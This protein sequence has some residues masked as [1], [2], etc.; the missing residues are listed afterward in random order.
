MK[1][2][3]LPPGL[4]LVLVLLVACTALRREP[5]MAAFYQACIDAT[6]DAVVLNVAAHPDDEAARTLTYLRRKHGIRTYT[7]Y[8][9]C[10]GG[11]QNAIGPEIGEDLARIRTRETLAAARFTGARVRWMGF[12]DFG[13]SKTAEE[14]FKAWGKRKYLDTL[15]RFLDQIDPDVVFTNHGP[16]RGHGHH[17]ATAIAAR[18]VVAKHPGLLLFERMPGDMWFE[19]PDVPSGPARPDVVFPVTEVDPSTG[20]SYARQAMR[21]WRMHRTQGM[22]AIGAWRRRADA[23][24]L[25]LPKGGNR[26][27]DLSALPSV[28]DSKEFLAFAGKH[29]V[30]PHQL[31]AG[32]RRFK[33]GGPIALQVKRA[34]DLL[35]ILRKLWN[36][37]NGDPEVATRLGRRVDA[38][39]RVI[40]EGLGIQVMVALDRERIP[41][42]GEGRLSLRIRSP[43]VTLEDV[44][45]QVPGGCAAP[46]SS[47]R[48]QA[49]VPVGPVS[50]DPSRVW[51]ATLKPTVSF[52]LGEVLIRRRPELHFT[53]V[54]PTRLTWEPTT[55]MLPAP[56][57]AEFRMV[58]LNVEWNG[59][60]ELRSHLEFDAPEGVLV[61]AQSEVVSLSPRQRR[62]KVPAAITLKPNS[63]GNLHVTARL[64]PDGSSSN[65]GT[66]ASS[67]LDISA[68]ALRRPPE[69][70][71]G[72][73]RGPDDTLHQVVEDLRL[74]HEVL[75]PVTLGTVDLR[76]FT[77]LAI[78]IRA[79][80]TRR[81]LAE[82]RERIFAFCRNGG[83]V[84]CFYHKPRE[85]NQREDQPL[86]APY[87][88]EVGRQRVSQEDAPVKLLRPGHRIWNHPNKITLAD[89]DGWVQERGL[90]FPAKWAKEWVPMLEM[91]D[92]GEKP[93]RGGLLYADY[94]RGQYV[95]CALVLYRQLRQG[96]AGAAR[97]VVNLLSR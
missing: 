53:P 84:V 36:E 93:L 15:E 2:V 51:P 37:W 76:S 3:R 79:Y 67:T 57:K 69:L 62:M 63:S 17:R 45:L 60:G 25:V 95:Y 43:T 19:K 65:G 1:G 74:D 94:G 42:A 71:V 73:I 64:D 55:L 23:W 47:S 77:T 33:D 6:T 8:S 34:K 40:L 9:T 68:V 54:P 12:E 41:V 56:R 11:G 46:A 92:E 90:N 72:L 85:W 52:R 24:K 59:E 13:Y 58:E 50:A 18:E 80:R 20:E 86:L 4:V 7:L 88:L 75:D 26:G 81:D 70:R 10:G 91:A 29:G 32:L 44:W 28:F 22:G 21:G 31:E 96:H 49:T 97:I 27:F 82:Q 48:M 14:T 61:Q 39:E 78:D 30:D 35:P 66:A 38:L 5:G 89:F 16:D 87:A 83:R